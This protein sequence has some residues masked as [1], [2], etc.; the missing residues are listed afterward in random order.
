MIKT[1][2]WYQLQKHLG[3]LAI[4]VKKILYDLLMIA[5]VYVVIFIAFAARWA[6]TRDFHLQ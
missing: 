4:S 6:A 1:F 2:Y 5:L 3:P